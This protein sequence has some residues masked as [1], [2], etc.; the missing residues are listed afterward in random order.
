MILK[1]CWVRPYVN[2]E[3]FSSVFC[4]LARDVSLTLGAAFREVFSGKD[5]GI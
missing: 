3:G 4:T 2:F 1:I 5:K